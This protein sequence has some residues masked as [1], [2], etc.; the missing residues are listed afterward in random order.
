MPIFSKKFSRLRWFV[1][2]SDGDKILVFFVFGMPEHHLAFYLYGRSAYT[3]VSFG[4]QEKSNTKSNYKVSVFTS[5]QLNI[6]S[7][8]S[9]EIMMIWTA[10]QNERKSTTDLLVRRI[11][12]LNQNDRTTAPRNGMI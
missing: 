12:K 8:R 3:F 2:V 11:E 1:C 6:N 4:E 9:F 5:T 7:K 10:T